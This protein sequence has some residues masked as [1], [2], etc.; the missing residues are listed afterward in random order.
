MNLVV[1]PEAEA[2]AELLDAQCWYA[3]RSPGL[4]FE[5]LMHIIELLHIEIRILDLFRRIRIH[6]QSIGPLVIDEYLKDA[7]LGGRDILL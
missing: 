3:A 7:R 5:I 1:R 2:E 4:G 6:P